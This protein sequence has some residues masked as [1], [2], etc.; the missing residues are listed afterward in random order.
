MLLPYAVIILQAVV[1]VIA[2]HKYCWDKKVAF[3]IRENVVVH[4]NITTLLEIK[5]DQSSNSFYRH[6]IRTVGD[7]VTESHFLAFA[8][9]PTEAVLYDVKNGGCGCK[10]F[11]DF[12]VTA[13]MSGQTIQ[14]N[15][16][17]SILTNAW[18]MPGVTADDIWIY[19]NV[20]SHLK[21]LGNN[22]MEL[23]TVQGEWR[24]EKSGQQVETC[25]F[26]EEYYDIRYNVTPK[27]FEVKPEWN[28]PSAS[29]CLK[30]KGKWGWEMDA[31]NKVALAKWL[32]TYEK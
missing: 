10:M 31:K 1:F 27:D 19:N 29:G 9:S 22:I 8:K 16:Y 32:R 24:S 25:T 6:A 15:N 21:D 18:T 11:D 13:C 30:S 12:F 2:D 20:T 14:Q 26:T 5:L 23:G 17:S 3:K 28:C 4:K 7:K